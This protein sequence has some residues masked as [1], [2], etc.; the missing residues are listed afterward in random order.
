MTKYYPEALTLLAETNTDDVS[1][2]QSPDGCTYVRFDKTPDANPCLYL[3]LG[4]ASFFSC[5]SS[6]MTAQWV[7]AIFLGLI[8]PVFAWLQFRVMKQ[9]QAIQDALPD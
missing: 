8:T 9:W 5:L 4:I 1:Y 6:I 3:V 7:D 2:K